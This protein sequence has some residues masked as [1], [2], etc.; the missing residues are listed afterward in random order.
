MTGCSREFETIFNNASVSKQ[1]RYRSFRPLKDPS[2]IESLVAEPK[3]T[4]HREAKYSSEAN[5]A[6]TK[7]YYI[8]ACATVIRV[9][10][11]RCCQWR[12]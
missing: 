2:S 12:H 5:P 11:K 8:D 7:I 3:P 4:S 6:L 9:L 1:L 10:A